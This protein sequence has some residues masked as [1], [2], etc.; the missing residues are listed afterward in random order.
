MY[1]GFGEERKKEED[2]QQMLAQGQSS[3]TKRKKK[4]NYLKN[5]PDSLSWL[6]GPCMLWPPPL[7]LPPRSLCSS[8]TGR[9]AVPWANQ[10]AILLRPLH[11]QFSLLERLFPQML[12]GLLPSCLSGFSPHVPSSQWPSPDHTV[13]CRPSNITYL[14]MNPS[15][16]SS[17][18]TQWSPPQSCHR[19]LYL[20][21]SLLR[22]MEHCTY[23]AW[24][25]F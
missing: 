7:L 12:P 22:F 20:S 3:S 9:P 25:T 19:T 23:Y 8:H 1:W 18:S 17:T 10:A 16:S 15:R 4:K 11:L 24:D 21:S 2:W 6:K 5:D 13:Q 14:L